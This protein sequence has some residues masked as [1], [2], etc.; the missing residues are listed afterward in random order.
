MA[1]RIEQSRKHGHHDPRWSSPLHVVSG[2]SL[3]LDEP[4]GPPHTPPALTLVGGTDA[5]PAPLDPS[6]AVRI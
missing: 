3:P 1:K 4:S 2:S 6:T 5:S